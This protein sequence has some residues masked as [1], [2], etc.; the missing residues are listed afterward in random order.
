MPTRNVRTTIVEYARACESA[1]IVTAEPNIDS[2]IVC[3][4]PMRSARC[5]PSIE[6]MMCPAPYTL[7]A[8]PACATL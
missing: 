5:P 1:S 4:R 6:A 3:R 7:T 2:A 8:R